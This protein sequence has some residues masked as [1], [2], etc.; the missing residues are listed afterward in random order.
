M[1]INKTMPNVTLVIPALD[2][3]ERFIPVIKDATAHGFH[4]IIVINDG[5][6]AE[7]MPNFPT[8]E[9]FPEVKVLTH[10][11]NRG[12]GAALKTA[13]AYFLENRPDSDGVITADSDGQHTTE[14]MLACV[15]AM[16]DGERAVI[17]G[18]RDFDDPNV[19][20]KSKFGNKC[21][22]T[23]FSV[24]C[25]IKISDTQ[26]GLR[27]I[28]REYVEK[29]MSAPGDR[30]EYETNMLF[31]IDTDQIPRREIKIHTVYFDKN[32]A[33]H[34]RPVVDSLRIYG[35][36]LRFAA[37]SIMSSVLDLLLHAIL[38][39]FVFTGG[40][41]LAEFAATAG[42]RVVSS[43]ANFMLN[44]R[45][46]FHSRANFLRTLFRYVCLAVPIMLASWLC[47][48]YISKLLDVEDAVLR[49][50]IKLP[51]DLMLYFI[52]FRIQRRWVFAE[53]KP[54]AEGAGQ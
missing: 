36:I 1:Y 35:L 46:V 32:S 24:F 27:V 19:P 5:S 6:H 30:Y 49:T 31:L 22:K 25:G 47:V 28:P 29:I 14:D 44:K 26:T 51:V 33:S 41:S 50:L 20:P 54:A 13:F 11:K 42:A 10:E 52:N 21:T 4:D 3:D 9:E 18:C 7:Y 16:Y 12:K 43:F 15:E 53:N 2:P 34:F 39:A 8:E 48:Y 40:G 23:A 45:L 37:S 17:L 38:L